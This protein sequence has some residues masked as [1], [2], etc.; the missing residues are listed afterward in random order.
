MFVVGCWALDVV[1]RGF[2]GAKR[3]EY[4]NL[5][6]RATPLQQRAKLPLDA[7]ASW[8]SVVGPQADIAG[9]NDS[10]IAGQFYVD[11]LGKGSVN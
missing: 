2:G 11:N 7:A 1:G 4:D 3:E 5:T 10:N 9:A 8:G 6:F